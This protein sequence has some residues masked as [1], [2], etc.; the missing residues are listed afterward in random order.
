MTRA[1]TQLADQLPLRRRRPLLLRRRRGRLHSPR[2]VEPAHRRGQLRLLRRLGPLPHAR[3]R[4]RPL[5]E[6]LQQADLRQHGEQIV[7]YGKSLDEDAPERKS[8][9][10]TRLEDGGKTIVSR[11]DVPAEE[12]KERLIMELV[13]TRKAEAKPPEK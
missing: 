7:L 10:V 6:E 4:H 1:A 12:G 3:H 2:L 5:A 13:M 11:Q 9:T 8:R